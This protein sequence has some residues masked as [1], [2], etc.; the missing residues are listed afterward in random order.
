MPTTNL[1]NANAQHQLG[2]NLLP[3]KQAL[4]KKDGGLRLDLRQLNR[5]VTR[6]KFKIITLKQVVSQTRSEDWFVKIDLEDAY[7]HVSI[8][9]IH[10]KFL[11]FS[12]VS[13]AYQYRVLPFGLALSPRTFTKCVDAA[14]AR[15]WLQGTHIL[16]YIDDWLILALSEQVGAQHRDVVLAHMKVLVL[17]L[18]AE[19]IV[20][21]PLQRTTYLGVVWDSTRM[22]ARMSP[23]RFD[24]ILTEVRRV[25][26][27]QSLT[28][29]QFQ[30]LLGLMVAASNVIPI[31][32]LYMRPL[33]WWRKTKGF[34]PRGNSLRM[35]KVTRRCLRAIDMWRK[36]WFLFMGA[37]ILSRLGQRP[38]EWMLHPEVVNQIWRVFGQV[39]VYLFATQETAQCPL[40][41]S[42]VHPAP[43]GLDAMVQTWPRLRLYT[44]PSITLFPVVL[45][46]VHRARLVYFW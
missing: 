25:K 45:A 2:N 39:M 9:S 18:N 29:K 10:R 27:G 4:P 31:G 38:G 41:Y 32:L 1:V 13:E 34:S 8:L 46:R 5:S 12:L 6:L 16:N 22:Q 11:R 44:F 23:A 17:R 30:R 15:L 35:I 40:W 14:L 19:K 43:L 37:D 7:F 42:L 20:L 21:S 33:Q 28:V 24:S 36:P 26:E 3:K